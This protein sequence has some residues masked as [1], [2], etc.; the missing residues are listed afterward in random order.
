MPNVYQQMQ[1]LTE[2]ITRYREKLLETEFLIQCSLVEN[3]KV[4]NILRFLV[5]NQEMKLSLEQVNK[6]IIN[7]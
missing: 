7:E 6:I 4:F 1:S 3:K 5:A 2:P